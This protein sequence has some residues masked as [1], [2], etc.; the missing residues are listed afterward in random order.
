MTPAEND[1]ALAEAYAALEQ[2]GIAI[3]RAQQ[4]ISALR[5]KTKR[6]PLTKGEV[7]KE[8]DNLLNKGRKG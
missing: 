1:R 2:A 8:F 4:A 5:P 3:L 7:I 6:K